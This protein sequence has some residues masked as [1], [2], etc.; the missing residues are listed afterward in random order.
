MF[1][2]PPGN[3]PGWHTH[4]YVEM[5]VPLTGNWRFCWG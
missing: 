5:F 2:A 4:D 1:E 3:G